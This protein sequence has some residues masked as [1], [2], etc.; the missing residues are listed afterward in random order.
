MGSVRRVLILC[1]LISACGSG[2][3][4]PTDGSTQ[5]PQD[6]SA[7]PMD[8]PPDGPPAVT[9]LVV[10]DGAGTITA[11]SAPNAYATATS[12]GR[13][14]IYNGETATSGAVAPTITGAD[15]SSFS[16]DAANSTCGSP[17]A[18]H[19]GCW[20]QVAFSPATAG[21]K[22]AT[23][24]V[25]GGGDPLP[26]ALTGLAPPGPTGLTADV[27]ALDFGL[28][29]R[30]ESKQLQVLLENVGTTTIT[31]G[32]RTA[33]APFTYNTDNCGATLTPGGACTLNVSFSS[34]SLGHFTGTVDVA[35]DA[36]ALHLPLDATILRLIQVSFDG[37]GAGTVT[38]LPS[39]INCPGT[40]SAG[41][42]GG[43]PVILT[44]SVNASN[45]FAHWSGICSGTSPTCTIP[46]PVD[47]YAVPR[48]AL[49]TDKKIHVA[50][51]GGPAYAIVAND[52][53]ST[54]CDVYVPSG[55]SV[56][57]HGFSASTLGGW[58]GDCVSSTSDCS[59][60]TVI[61]NRTVTLTTN[62]DPHETATLSPTRQVKG[63]A[64]TSTGDL[65]VGS[66]DD[67]LKTSITGTVAWTTAITGGVRGLAVD[68]TDEIFA[69]GTDTVM[70]LSATG[71]VVW[72]KNITANVLVYA[73]N[74]AIAVSPDG[75]I[76]AVLTTT[77][78]RVLDAA[79]ADRF[80]VTTSHNPSS[81]TVAP[82]GTIAL[83]GDDLA[84][85]DAVEASRYS[86]T[87]TALTSFGPL[88]GT[89]H[90]ALQYNS[91]NSM[92]VATHGENSMTASLLTTT[93]TTAFFSNEGTPGLTGPWPSGVIAT[94][95]GECGKIRLVNM[96]S[97]GMKLDIYSATGTVVHT[98]TKTPVFSGT[99]LGDIGVKTTWIASGGTNRLAIAGSFA[100]QPWIQVLDLP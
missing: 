23:L 48:F 17:L 26:I 22:N 91:T 13:L 31:L 59:L 100:G 87:G 76:I 35:S 99:I 82:D 36:N 2:H 20:L 9:S 42:P 95:T 12:R 38:S 39:G 67:V 7:V 56:T 78:M 97:G 49:A 50:F 60:G 33:T 74:P 72:T 83:G 58:S 53:C 55:T 77:G 93:G 98:I 4:T 94:P 14:F 34:A 46:S 10:S 15:A 92:C 63:I 54:D 69:I 85:G 96:S 64:V 47:G 57:L 5:P 30:N 65:I 62:P 32:A 51:A 8:A 41:F 81:V 52:A 68:A 89:L 44:E 3:N 86:A 80:T 84:I 18:S 21:T 19:D 88:P 90:A 43:I 11:W 29:N 16:I 70:K 75:T 37:D 27:A 6:G 28:M 79:G 66:P 1:F 71:T 40:C 73:N 25:P 24:I 61:N 45:L